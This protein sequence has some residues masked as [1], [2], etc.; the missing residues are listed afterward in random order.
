M[1]MSA[2]TY[3]ARAAFF[4]RHRAYTFKAIAIAIA[5]TL[6]YL[7]PGAMIQFATLPDW[8]RAD[9]YLALIVVSTLGG[10][11]IHAFYNSGMVVSCFI[12]GVQF[13]PINLAYTMTSA[14]V[15]DPSL[16]ITAGTF[17]LIMGLYGAI[18]G[19]TGFLLGIGVRN[20][21]DLK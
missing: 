12:A 9:V 1:I 10:A 11:A 2:K 14:S 8:Y 13:T 19:T 16:I 18:I 17:F 4:G 3:P 5:F 7:I 15:G 6:I 21:L 20:S